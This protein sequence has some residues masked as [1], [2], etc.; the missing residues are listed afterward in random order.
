[1]SDHD[2]IIHA[3]ND[4]VGFRGNS[5]RVSVSDKVIE[6]HGEVAKALDNT[7]ILSISDGELP[8][9]AW[10][11]QLKFE[12]ET[13]SILFPMSKSDN[14]EISESDLC[15]IRQELK[16]MLYAN[17]FEY[18]LCL[19]G[20]E[21]DNIEP[22]V[23]RVVPANAG[24]H[25]LRKQNGFYPYDEIIRATQTKWKGRGSCSRI[26]TKNEVISFVCRN[27]R[28]SRDEVQTVALFKAICTKLRR[29]KNSKNDKPEI[30]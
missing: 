1:M 25:I 30:C 6:V 14:E 21:S 27:S 24:L 8:G 16:E 2:A 28:G 23:S 12:D 13:I 22:F 5:C 20:N 17:S 11:V 19:R 9:V 29:A 26:E 10:T 4:A 7:E 18:V 15:D 3:K